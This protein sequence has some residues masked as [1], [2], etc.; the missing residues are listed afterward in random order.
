[1]ADT[2]AEAV[3]TIS[4]E[5]DTLYD[6]VSDLPNMG[7][8]SPENTGG[9]WLGGATGPVV[10]AK[11]RGN[12]KAGWRRWSTAVEV[13]AAD[14]GKR[15]AF[16]VKSGPFDVADWTYEFDAAG[17]ETTVVEKWDDCRPGWMK[18]LSGPVMGIADRG[19]HNENAMAA[20]L[21]ALKHAVEGAT[22]S[23]S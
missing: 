3:A 10:G 18:A 14:R 21:S 17:S 20:T 4:A 8:F 23:S 11:F 15:F 9:R 1:M 6:L 16:H 13:T 5:P 7:K 22:T 2:H 12:N 19:H